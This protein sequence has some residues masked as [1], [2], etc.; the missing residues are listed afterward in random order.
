MG[1]TIIITLTQTF[2]NSKNSPGVNLKNIEDAIINMYNKENSIANINNIQFVTNLQMKISEF[3]NI[4]NI[5]DKAMKD[6]DYKK[7]QCIGWYLDVLSFY[8]EYSNLQSLFIRY[9]NKIDNFIYKYAEMCILE[10]NG[11]D[12]YND[13]LKTLK[14]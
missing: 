12:K 5:I 9:L 3:V 4:K 13:V 11:K 14:I 1:D 7:L 10:Y 8:P 6:K 2:K